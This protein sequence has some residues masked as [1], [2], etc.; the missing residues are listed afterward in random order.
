MVRCNWRMRPDV[1]LLLCTA[2]VKVEHCE[3]D[4]CLSCNKPDIYCLKHESGIATSISGSV[5]EL[6][7]SNGNSSPCHRYLLLPE[8]ALQT[9]TSQSCFADLSSSEAP[10]IVLSH[11]K[12]LSNTLVAYRFL[13]QDQT[14][15]HKTTHSVALCTTVMPS[16]QR[17]L[18]L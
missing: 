15:L 8:N 11:R 7:F 12:R 5:L 9:A 10:Q 4:L 17:L 2:Q 16:Q 3:K 6:S 1:L 14:T 13:L 18:S